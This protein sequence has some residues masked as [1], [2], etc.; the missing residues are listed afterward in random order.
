MIPMKSQNKTGK[1]A[2]DKSPIVAEVPAA[3]ADERLAVEF[4]ER[5]R[6]GD[7]PCC[8][9]C[10]SVSVYQMKD[11][12]TGERSKRWL[13]RCHDCR[14]KQY[15][16][17]VGTVFE[18]SRIPLRHWVYAFWAA[19]ASKK[20]VSALQIKRQTG[21]SYKSA[22]FMMHRVRYAM[23]PD[24][25]E[26]PKL[27]GIVEVDETYV[28]G[29]PRGKPWKHGQPTREKYTDKIPVVALLQRGGEVRP[30][31]VERVDAATLRKAITENV[32]PGTFIM[33]DER[34]AYRDICNDIGPHGS[35]NH[36]KGEYVHPKYPIIHSNTVEGFFSILKR[37]MYGTFH[38]VSKRRL[39]LYLAEF[40]F[41]YN[42]RKMEDG[43]RTERVIRAANGKRLLYR[44][45]VKKTG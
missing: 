14:G 30:M 24:H 5:R 42:T 39:P 4:L 1:P 40:G 18:D 20:G 32:E 9:R 31:A 3:C 33:T 22:L 37:G 38:A 36:S 8:P 35:T 44:E 2:Q 21:V 17:R 27:S 26:P 19:C 6:W 10:G 12:A 13:W 28:G 11:A 45:P 16:V 25:P 43:E 41:R 15:T 34:P 23:M 7:S 29:K